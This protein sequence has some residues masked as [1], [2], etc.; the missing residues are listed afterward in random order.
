VHEPQSSVPPQPSGIEPQLAPCAVHV[1]DGQVTIT[2]NVILD[3]FPALSV[4]VHVTG[5]V[6]MLKAPGPGEHAIAVTQGL[7]V[8]VHGG[9]SSGPVEQST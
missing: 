5:V 3:V 9:K 2:E 8:G 7:K 4:A 1:V 6:P